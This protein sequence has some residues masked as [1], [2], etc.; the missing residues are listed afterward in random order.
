[1]RLDG[2][3]G[4]AA[5]VGLLAMAMALSAGRAEAQHVIGVGGAG[6]GANPSHAGFGANPS[7]AGFGANPS[8]R[9][10]FGGNGSFYNIRNGVGYGLGAVGGYGYGGYGGLG[11]GGYSGYG[12]YGYGLGYGGYGGYGLGYGGYG[13]GYPNWSYNVFVPVPYGPFGYAFAP[14]N[15]YAYDPSIL[16]PGSAASLEAGWIN[17]YLGGFGY[18]GFGYGFG[19]PGI[20]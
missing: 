1:M 14:P 15:P 8:L 19:Y 6:F 16:V 5:R 2:T 10:N 18:G 13:Y 3:I 9:T 7:H 12:G 20:W 17:P 4:Q 11:Y